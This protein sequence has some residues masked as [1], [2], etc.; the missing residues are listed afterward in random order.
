[1]GGFN[2]QSVNENGGVAWAKQVAASMDPSA[3]DA[4][5]TSYQQAAS[6]LAKVQSTL[7]NVKNNLA[8]AWVGDA[9][10]QAQNSFQSS[11]TQ[12]AQAH[13]TI[14]AV[15]P[16]LQNAKAAQTEFINTVN[17][18]PDEKTVPSNSL[19]DEA[20]NFFFGTPLPSQ[21]AE[22]HNTTVRTQAADALNKL[23]S[24]YDQSAGEMHLAVGGGTTGGGGAGS[25]YTPPSVSS[26]SGDGFAGGYQENINGGQTVTAGYVPSPGGG[27]PNTGISANPINGTPGAPAPDPIAGPVTG[28]PEPEPFPIEA[29]PEPSPVGG[30]A[31]LITD[32]HS[33]PGGTS[34]NLI[35]GPAEERG[36]GFGSKAGVFDENGFSDGQL[37]GGRGTGTRVRTGAVIEEEPEPGGSRGGVLGEGENSE[38]MTGMR[39]GRGRGGMGGESEEEGSSSKYSRGRYFDGEG[40]ESER[41]SRAPVRSVFE[42]A[43]DGDGKKV[44]MMGGRRGGAAGEDEEEEG[45][46]RP[47]FLTEDE[48]WNTAQR[49]VPPVIQ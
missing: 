32:E 13:D 23:S 48:F 9:S 10:D 28:G 3:L 27:G 46:K 18:I 1:M 41:P 24:S 8:S 43:T 38:S 42:N 29:E 31:E 25:G 21:V 16:P 5:I 11:I 15:V 30:G 4:Q 12:A 22:Q 35:E 45:G 47:S 6:Q 20:S 36:S 2:Q 7:Q 34:E 14:Q 33:G 17:A 26:S 39:G 40:E 49:V 19:S 37:T 44:N